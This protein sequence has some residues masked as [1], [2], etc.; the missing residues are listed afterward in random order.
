MKDT[1]WYD[2]LVTRKNK[3]SEKKFIEDYKE[4][5]NGIKHG[6]SWHNY[7]VTKFNISKDYLREKKASILDYIDENNKW[8]KKENVSST[9]KVFLQF[10]DI[11]WGDK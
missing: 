6:V 4:I 7:N 11:D 8:A 3:I 9:L 2:Y 10:N 1:N 5:S